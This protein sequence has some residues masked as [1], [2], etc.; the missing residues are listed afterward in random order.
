MF[1]CIPKSGYRNSIKL[2]IQLLGHVVVFLH[3][4]KG[5]YK[6]L[7]ANVMNYWNDKI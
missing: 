3:H 5:A 6:V 4:P 2:I 7:S 1:I